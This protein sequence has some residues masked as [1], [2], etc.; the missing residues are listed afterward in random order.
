MKKLASRTLC[1][2]EKVDAEKP[3]IEKH[4]INLNEK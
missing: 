4:K 1:A 3:T 2:K